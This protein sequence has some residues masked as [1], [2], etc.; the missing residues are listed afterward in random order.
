MLLLGLSACSLW[1]GPAS[2]GAN[3]S[4][5]RFATLAAMQQHSS[6][7]S[8]G[9]DGQV[10][11][12]LEAAGFRLIGPGV[13]GGGATSGSRAYVAEKDGTVV[14]AFRGTLAGGLDYFQNVATDARP[15][16]RGLKLG[17][18]SRMENAKVHTGFQNDYNKLR[19]SIL[20]ALDEARGKQLFIC[21][22][23]LGAALATICTYDLAKNYRSHFASI[24][25]IVSGSPKVGDEGFKRAY[26]A[27]VPNHLRVTIFG[28]PITNTPGKLGVHDYAHVG[29]ELLISADGELITPAKMEDAKKRPVHAR[30][31][32]FKAIDN[33]ATRYGTETT[34]T[35]T[36]VVSLPGK[37]VERPEKAT[38]ESPLP[39]PA[40][41]AEAKPEKQGWLASRALKKAA[42]SESTQA[43]E[44]ETITESTPTLASSETTN[45]EPKTRPR[46]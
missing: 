25:P 28:D 38:V 4:P 44:E 37:R 43:L 45:R 39:E 7:V 41:T 1:D 36:A 14:I 9:T 13:F 33:L 10:R 23:S 8:K 16:P 34:S 40:E 3:V 24:H 5:A 26:E 31:A 30:S 29:R 15:I 35:I 42:K 11:Q 32:Y 18:G 6:W 17:D 12:S 20:S 19:P 27:V 22:H 46:R 21:G 2:L